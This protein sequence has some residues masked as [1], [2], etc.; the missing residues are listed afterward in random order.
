MTQL[1]SSLPAVVSQRH[2]W[3]ML[4]STFTLN[5]LIYFMKNTQ[6]WK[7]AD[8]LIELVIKLTKRCRLFALELK[9]NQPVVRL[10][11]RFTL[12]S[13]CFPITS[14]NQKLFK[15]MTI[16]WSAIPSTH[17]HLVTEQ[18][19]NGISNYSKQRLID[20]QEAIKAQVSSSYD[21]ARDDSDDD[22]FTTEFKEGDIVDAKFSKPNFT[23]WYP[24]EVIVA[25]DEMVRVK[26]CQ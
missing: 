3:A 10:I 11:E 25:L 15:D 6:F 9:K 5:Y 12:E 13:P 26:I 23:G 16:N 2:T 22:C 1:N 7:T 20:F 18:K 4:V 19:V 21:N 24:A 14:S 17:K 8:S